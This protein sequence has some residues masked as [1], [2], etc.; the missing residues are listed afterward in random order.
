MDRGHSPSVEEYG[1]AIG[2]DGKLKPG[3]SRSPVL[4]GSGQVLGLVYET[5]TL[6]GKG[7][8]LVFAYRARIIQSK[9]PE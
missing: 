5:S 8:N 9:L 1:T 2:F 6:E 4:N 3:A 7:I